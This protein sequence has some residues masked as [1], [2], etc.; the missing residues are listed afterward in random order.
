MNVGDKRI[1]VTG[2]A[3]FIGSHFVESVHSDGADVLVLDDLSTGE[4]RLVPEGVRL[5]NSSIR[6]G[7]AERIVESFSPDIVVHL[8][9]NHYI[10]YCNENPEETFN[11]NVMGTR[12]LLTAVH[13]VEPEQFLF[14]SSAA[15][16]PPEE[17][18]HSERDPVSPSDIYGRTK[19]VGE[20]LVER[21]ERTTATDFTVA[22]LFNVYGP[23]ETNEHVIPAILRQIR[24]GSRTVRLGN[25]SPKRDFIYVTDVV[26]ALR[27]ILRAQTRDELVFNVGTGDAYSVEEIV[28]TV[29][30]L[31]GET[32]T[33]TQ[34]DE[35][36]R[37]SDRPHLEADVSKISDSVG[38]TPGIVFHE[39]LERLI[40]HHG[41]L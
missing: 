2:G 35:R 26:A 23:T 13:D 18:V 28:S 6:S 39:G 32:V 22:R 40:S 34:E 37:E 19:L 16:Y 27:A 29:S 36:V 25:L 7:A 33:I 20:D 8:A 41:I 14:A 31:L 21:F 17:P 12:N 24:D 38:W 11:T 15:V 5:E 3:G 30:D 1:L 10:P 4:R 9:A